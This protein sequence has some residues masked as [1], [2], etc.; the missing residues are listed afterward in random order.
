MDDPAEVEGT[1]DEKLRAF[2][3]ARDLI[4][5][6][7]DLLLALPIEKLDRLTLANRLSS[8]PMLSV[9]PSRPRSTERAQP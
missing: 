7:I 5:R 3:A 8:I 4:A 6:R 2:V 9:P 1:E